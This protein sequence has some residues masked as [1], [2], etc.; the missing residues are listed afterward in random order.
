MLWVSSRVSPS[1]P[2][3]ARR[4]LPARSTRWILPRRSSDLTLAEEVFEVEVPFME[5][6]MRDST[7]KVR[8]A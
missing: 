3:R 2:D 1:A 6:R 8:I 4:S 5:D 7:W